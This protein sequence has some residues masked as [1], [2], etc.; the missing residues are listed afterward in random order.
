LA[1]ETGWEKQGEDYP[2]VD[3]EGMQVVDFDKSAT[4]PNVLSHSL[5]WKIQAVLAKPHRKASAQSHVSSAVSEFHQ[6]LG[7]LLNGI[8]S[9]TVVL[10]PMFVQASFHF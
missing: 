7:P 9:G 10:I 6:T 5:D 8:R 3:L 4:G 2:I 1:R